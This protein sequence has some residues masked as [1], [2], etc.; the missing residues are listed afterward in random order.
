MQLNWNTLFKALLGYLLGYAIWSIAHPAWELVLVEPAE[1]LVRIV[2]S[3]EVTRLSA[4]EEKLVVVD[5][6]DFP[7]RSARPTVDLG[8]I[9]FNIMLLTALFATAPRPF[10]DRN[11]RGVLYA[12]IVLWAVHLFTLFASVQAIYAL[13]LGAWSEARYGAIARNFWGGYRHFYVILGVFAFPI[14]A[15]WAFRD[16]QEGNAPGGNSR[17]KKRSRMR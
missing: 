13:Q 16:T 7:R 2:E 8:D 6:S 1:V 3:P 9:T 5:R 4:G 12:A 10:S 14:A 11:L 15:W 17:N